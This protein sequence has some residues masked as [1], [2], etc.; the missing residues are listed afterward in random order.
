MPE[1]VHSMRPPSSNSNSA[2]NE[3]L[4][5]CPEQCFKAYPWLRSQKQWLQKQP[6][7]PDPVPRAKDRE[8]APVVQKG[9][10]AVFAFLMAPHVVVKDSGKFHTTVHFRSE[11]NYNFFGRLNKTNKF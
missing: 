1:A 4:A 7:W 9:A 6:P 2:S 3:G 8:L 5:R 11:W 10:P